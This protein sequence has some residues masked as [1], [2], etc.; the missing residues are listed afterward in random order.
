MH[1]ELR[2]LLTLDLHA[3]DLARWR[4]SRRALAA[5]TDPELGDTDTT[6]G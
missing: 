5:S 2:T 6:L 4:A 3:I 1:A